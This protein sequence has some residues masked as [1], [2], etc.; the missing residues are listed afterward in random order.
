MGY[1]AGNRQL[2]GAKD[3][4]PKGYF[5][6]KSIIIQ[7]QDWLL[8]QGVAWGLGHGEFDPSLSKLNATGRDTLRNLDV[9]EPWM[10]KAPRICLRLRAWDPY[11][12]HAPPAVFTVGSSINLQKISKGIILWFAFLDFSL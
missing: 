12:E 7:N 3:F 9:S 4:N 1:S 2:K 6:M 8:E 5:E 11:F 10:L